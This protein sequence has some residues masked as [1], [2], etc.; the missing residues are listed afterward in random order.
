MASSLDKENVRRM[1]DEFYKAA[2]YPGWNGDVNEGVA[3][4]FGKMLA[5][6]AQCS[7][8]MSWVPRPPGGKATIIWLCTSLGSGAIRRLREQ[9]SVTCMKFVINNLG[10]ELDIAA[11]FGN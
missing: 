3:A 9:S 8:G 11:A 6:T 4:V 5:E 10:R 7:R 2:E 1:I